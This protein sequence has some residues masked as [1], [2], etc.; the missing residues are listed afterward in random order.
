MAQ[1]FIEL[2]IVALPDF[3]LLKV[4]NL[5]AIGTAVVGS[6]HPAHADAKSALCKATQQTVLEVIVYVAK[7]L[8]FHAR[9][10]DPQV[11]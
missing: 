10:E 9:I 6:Q 7:V 5:P 8:E 2:R 3:W 11:H 4:G 1:Q